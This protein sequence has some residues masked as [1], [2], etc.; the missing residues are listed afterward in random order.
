MSAL[1]PVNF[2]QLSMGRLLEISTFTRIIGRR[3][4]RESTTVAYPHSPN[5]IPSRHA[6]RRSIHR[7]PVLRASTLITKSFILSATT[8]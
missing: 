1:N 8:H 6:N 7:E 4:H 2:P 5:L 3:M